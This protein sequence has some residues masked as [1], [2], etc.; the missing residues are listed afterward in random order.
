MLQYVELVEG[1]V[2]SMVTLVPFELQL[3]VLVTLLVDFTV[4]LQLRSVTFL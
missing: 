1:T 2:A 3:L 4:K